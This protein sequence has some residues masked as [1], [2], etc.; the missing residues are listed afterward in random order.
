MVYDLVD[1]QHFHYASSDSELDD[2]AWCEAVDQMIDNDAGVNTAA[3]AEVAPDNKPQVQ[4]SR[5]RITGKRP[6]VPREEEWQPQ[7]VP[8]PG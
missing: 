7:K 2:T 3:A 6:P 1:T 4:V 5:L 8:K